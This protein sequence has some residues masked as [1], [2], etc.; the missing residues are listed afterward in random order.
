MCGLKECVWERLVIVLRKKIFFAC[1]FLPSFCSIFF[2][3][4]CQTWGKIILSSLSLLKNTFIVLWH[5]SLYNNDFQKKSVTFV[6]HL[7]YIV[8][9][10][11]FCSKE[12]ICLIFLKTYPGIL[13]TYFNSD[14]QK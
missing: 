4:S 2:S 12:G 7:M 1:H 3:L 9:L 11:I 8:S 10:N 13:S 14:V 6:F 5:L